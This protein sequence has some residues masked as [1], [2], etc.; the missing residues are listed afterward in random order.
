MA[1]RVRCQQLVKFHSQQMCTAASSQYMDSVLQE[2]KQ[3]KPFSD[4]PGPPGLPYI[5]TML[6]YR[7]GQIFFR[8]K[9]TLYIFMLSTENAITLSNF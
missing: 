5:G 2:Y 8:I 6:L 7:K 3:A 9:F 4:I 1:V